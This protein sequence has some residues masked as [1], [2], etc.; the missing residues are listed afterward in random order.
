MNHIC[1]KCK[2]EITYANDVVCCPK[3]GKTY[4]KWCWKS[5][6]NCVCCG[7]LNKDYDE[8]LSKRLDNASKN[9][10]DSGMFSN[11][12]EK[13]K[14]LATVITVVGIVVGII[15]FFVNA[16][17]DED[18]V[19]PGLLLGA[20]IALA[21]WVSSFALYGF[22]ALITSTQNT[23]RLTREMLKEIKDK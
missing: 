22:G 18:M 21:S 13:L 16:T 20:G 1:E 23:E 19:F 14:G 7:A 2:G 15:V 8:E 4:H 5:I 11:I 12:G 6:T 3:C 17:M 10:G 9:D